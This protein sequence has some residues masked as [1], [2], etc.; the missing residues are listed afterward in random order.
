MSPNLFAETPV[1]FSEVARHIPGRPHVSTLH[2]WRLDGVRGAKLE[3]FL[4]GGRRFTTKEAIGRFLGH[5]NG[6]APRP[7]ERQ[8]RDRELRVAR[9]RAELQVRGKHAGVRA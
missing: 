4:V 7:T 5:L 8:E 9:A 1:P 2:R 6:T 3:T